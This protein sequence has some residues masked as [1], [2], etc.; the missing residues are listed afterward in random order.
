MIDEIDVMATIGE[1]PSQAEQRQLVIAAQ[2]GD[3][4]ARHA[5]IRA[6]MAWARRLVARLKRKD[7]WIEFE[8]L[9][10]SAFEG[11]CRAVDRYD[12][13]HRGGA[14]FT[15]YATYWVRAE[16]WAERARHN[17][18]KIGGRWERKTLYKLGKAIRRA[19]ARGG[20]TAE[21]VADE[22]GEPDAAR[23]GALMA[24]LS[25]VELDAPRGDGGTTLLATL[26]A[27]ASETY[28]VIS[29]EDRVRAF[30]TALDAHPDPRAREIVYRRLAGDLLREI[31]EDLGL[32]AE[33]VRQIE[34]ATRE[35]ISL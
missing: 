3:L 7:D 34:K 27:R 35:E 12:P 28:E 14:S 13:A 18:V 2:T 22:L 9:Q 32:S 29:V 1:I 23:V 15:S 4:Q 25:P 26:A 5:L 31:G 11:L 19:G 17:V 30:F 10:Q 8:D 24:A 6:N 33:R 20:V 21:T 16:I